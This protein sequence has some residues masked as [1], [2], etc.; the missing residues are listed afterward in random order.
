MLKIL[1]KAQDTYGYPNQ[2]MVCAEEC[3]ELASVLSRTHKDRLDIVEE[4]ADVTVCLHH[5]YIMFGIDSGHHNPFYERYKNC[6]FNPIKEL[7]DLACLLTK[8]PRYPDHSTALENMKT[9]VIE[10]TAVVV[11]TLAQLKNL[12]LIYDDEIEV[13]MDKKLRR[14][15][16]WLKESDNMYQTTIDRELR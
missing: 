11:L 4:I 13:V 10:K 3:C 5:I 7:C 6:A 9:K 8:Y 14:L 15:E 2:M 12:Y 16:R 1:T